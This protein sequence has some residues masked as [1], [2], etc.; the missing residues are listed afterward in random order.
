[1]ITPRHVLIV[2]AG[3]GIGTALAIQ[4][5][6]SG[7]HV[8][9]AARSAETLDAATLAV[10]N[11]MPEPRLSLLQV[12]A[13]DPFALRRIIADHADRTEVPIDVA[14]FNVSMWVPGGWDSDPGEVDAGLRTG[15]VSGL[16]MAQALI[17]SM[18]ELPQAT[19]LFTGGGTADRP[20]TA[21]LG[22]GL[23]KA[24][25]RN[26]ALGLDAEL[27]GTSIR[28][29]T[30]TIHG[31]IAPDTPFAPERIAAAL[32]DLAVDREGPCAVDFTG[33]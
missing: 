15:V 14:L 27:S 22:L 5:A 21:S 31:T 11:S 12:D 7:A 4:A 8:T 18:R 23:Q 24:A 13:G 19:L 2:G 10:Y 33:G 16:A 6:W 9:L 32:W 25:L 1:M 28:A 3:P 20:M 29:R 30:L 26:L 17:P